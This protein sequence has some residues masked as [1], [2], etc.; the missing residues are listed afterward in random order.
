M[1][2][3]SFPTVALLIILI[4]LP[5]SAL[6]SRAMASALSLLILILV[7]IFAVLQIFAGSLSG[8]LWAVRTAS[9]IAQIRRRGV[10]ETLCLLPDGALGV[11]WVIC[12]ACLYW[13]G[14]YRDFDSQYTWPIRM[15]FIFGAAV[16]F[17][18]SLLQ[19]QIWTLTAIIV[20]MLTFIV[21]FHIEDVQSIVLA[22]MIGMITPTY[23][24][25]KVEVQ[26]WTSAFYLFIQIAIYTLVVLL[27]SAILPTIYR[28]TGMTGWLSQAS[29]PIISLMMLY[30][31][32]EFVILGFWRGLLGRLETRS[33]DMPSASCIMK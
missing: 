11:S 18:P 22:C 10:Y 16:Y 19:D 28:V 6:A 7:P 9:T 21:W 29:I 2:Q 24:H 13:D 12:M 3:R 1:S 5:L 4:F 8:L 15:F 30:L 23:T 14:K 26:I 32:R 20:N 27:A 17:S 33:Q 25:H 31:I